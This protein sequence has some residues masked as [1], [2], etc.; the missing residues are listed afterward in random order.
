MGLGKTYQSLSYIG[1]L[2][3]AGTISNA[4]VVVPVSVLRMWEKEAHTVIKR[5]CVRNIQIT[6][7]SSD[8]SR[9]RRSRILREALRCTSKN[10]SLI[11]TTYGLI[12]GAYSADFRLEGHYWGYVILDEGHK[13]KNASTK[14]AKNCRYICLNDNTRR[15]LLTGMYLLPLR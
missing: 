1:G 11:I 8:L 2:M 3:R 10:P 13:I 7:V 12:G 14:V 9:E 6:V 5:N 4:L 15:L